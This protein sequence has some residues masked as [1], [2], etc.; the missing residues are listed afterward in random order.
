LLKGFVLR[1]TIFRKRG[2]KKIGGKKNYFH[3][4]V[5]LQ[6]SDMWHRWL[7][8][9]RGKAVEIKALVSPCKVC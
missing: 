9:P 5:V 4:S 6:S 3:R 7:Q 8:K 1:E 2:R